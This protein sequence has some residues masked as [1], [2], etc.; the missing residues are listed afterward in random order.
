[1]HGQCIAQR[2]RGCSWVVLAREHIHHDIRRFQSDRKAPRS[3]A[4]MPRAWIERPK[5]LQ[6]RGRAE[7]EVALSVRT[8]LAHGFDDAR[9]L[10]DCRPMDA[11]VAGNDDVRVQAVAGF[12]EDVCDEVDRGRVVG[13]LHHR[14][15]DIGREARP[16][17]SR[18]LT[19]T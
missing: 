7:V 12:R 16:Y 10:P 2:L 9:R 5:R 18:P 3:A 6:H 4:G 17:S 8:A 19:I 1:M 11:I 14:R 15:T 13:V